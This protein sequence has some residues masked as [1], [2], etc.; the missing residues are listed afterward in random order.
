VDVSAASAWSPMPLLAP[1]RNTER[2]MSS[3][4]SSSSV[5]PEKRPR[6]SP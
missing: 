2:R 1:C 5:G 4:S 6:P 3:R